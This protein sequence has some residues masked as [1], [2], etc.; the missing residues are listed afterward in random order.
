M[1]KAQK[2]L[3]ELKDL[4]KELFPNAPELTDTEN[5]RNRLLAVLLNRDEVFRHIVYRITTVYK[6]I[7]LSKHP[8]ETFMYLC[9]MLNQVD[10]HIRNIKEAQDNE[11]AD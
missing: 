6:L 2:Q 11:P 7:R 5:Y 9:E 1:N 3:T 8:Q 10:N 4:E